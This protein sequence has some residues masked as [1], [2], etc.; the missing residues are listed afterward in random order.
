MLIALEI[1]G[2]SM[3]LG[4]GA[5]NPGKKGSNDS[6]IET[7]ND[8]RHNWHS[9]AI[10]TETSWCRNS[11]WP[12]A[13]QWK[14]LENLQRSDSSLVKSQLHRRSLIISTLKIHH[15]ITRTR[16]SLHHFTSI[17]S[18]HPAIRCHRAMAGSAC[19]RFSWVKCSKSRKLR[20]TWVHLAWIACRTK[21]L[22]E[23]AVLSR[24][25]GWCWG[26]NRCWGIRRKKKN[27]SEIIWWLC[28]VLLF[29]FK[30][31]GKCSFQIAISPAIQTD[32]STPMI[33]NHCL[34]T[35]VHAYIYIYRQSS[36]SLI[37]AISCYYMRI[38]W[39]YAW[40]TWYYCILYIIYTIYYIY[41]IY[42]YA[43]RASPPWR[44]KS[45]P[46]WDA[47]FQ[48]FSP[49]LWSSRMMAIFAKRSKKSDCLE[50]SIFTSWRYRDLLE[51]MAEW[52]M[53]VIN[54]NMLQPLRCYRCY[55]DSS[56]S[57][58]FMILWWLLQL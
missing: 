34:F 33:G 17:T 58:D 8:M 5:R 27:S 46:S 18:S 25:A 56:C 15:N 30:T 49:S 32:S 55:E 16:S 24:T 28:D 4:K 10:S 31:S 43:P 53:K 22:P 52:T 35:M 45:W 6:K 40:Y 19:C 11:C 7:G 9:A 38:T 37:I 48:P 26:Q 13:N 47:H 41:T 57:N 3:F 42:I 12:M 23:I 51:M 21:S 39:P 36:A 54:Y 29:L 50:T 20:G 2:S 1:S 14:I 44:Q